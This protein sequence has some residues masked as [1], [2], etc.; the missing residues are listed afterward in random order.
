[1]PMEMRD[2]VKD[3]M[4]PKV[5]TLLHFFTDPPPLKGRLHYSFTVTLLTGETGFSERFPPT[6]PPDH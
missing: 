5:G 4:S 3:S 2:N 1:M 6:L